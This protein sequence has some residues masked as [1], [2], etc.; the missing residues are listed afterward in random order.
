MELWSKTFE[1]KKKKMNANFFELQGKTITSIQGAEENSDVVNIMTSDGAT[2]LLFHS[3]VCCEYVRVFNIV[4]DIESVIGAEISLAEDDSLDTNPN[5]SYSYR[6]E[7]RTW[8]KFTIITINGSKLEIWWLG[9]SNGYY[10]E[11]VSVEK[12]I[13][14]TKD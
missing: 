9:E 12:L 5:V 6:N 8:T 1:N 13:K 14:I 3:Q 4:G 11:T 7:S 10:R 2:Y